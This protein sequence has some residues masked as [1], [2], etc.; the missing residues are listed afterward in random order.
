MTEPIR[1]VPENLR[2]AAGRHRET[3]EYLSTIP[4]S[5]GDIQASLDSLGP[6]YRGLAEAG[7]Q[8]LD[9][10]RRCYVDQ[11]VE[12][13]EMARNLDMVAARWEQHERDAAAEFRGL[14]DDR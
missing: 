3:A 12:H 4:A 11:A 5:H 2:E 6:I 10:R 1:V 13:A 8:L 7:R 9:E 14:R